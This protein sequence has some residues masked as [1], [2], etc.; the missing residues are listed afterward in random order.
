MKELNYQVE[1]QDQD[2]G[3]QYVVNVEAN[4]DSGARDAAVRLVASENKLDQNRL[5]ASDPELAG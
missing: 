1:V 3:S 5:I 4:S 2:T